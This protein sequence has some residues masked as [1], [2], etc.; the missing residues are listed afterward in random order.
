MKDIEVK[1]K[2]AIAETVEMYGLTE[3]EAI[4][5]FRFYRWNKDRISDALLEGLETI[6]VR[7]GAGLP[8]SDSPMPQADSLC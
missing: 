8:E 2:E 5:I 1:I 3:D 4:T 7:T 6:K